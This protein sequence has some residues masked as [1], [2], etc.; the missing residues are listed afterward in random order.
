[1]FVI[2]P[3]TRAQLEQLARW[4]YEPP[5]N[6][7]DEA[8]AMAETALQ[9]SYL[10]L[11]SDLVNI[12][13]A[14]AYIDSPF[15]G[16]FREDASGELG[17]L[18][19]FVQY[20]PMVSEN[21]APVIRLGLGMNPAQCGHGLGDAFVRAIL[22]DARDRYPSA[23]IDLEVHTW[24]IRAIKVYERLGFVI[25]DTYRLHEDLCDGDDCDVHNMVYN[26]A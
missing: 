16:V 25:V 18:F 12:D 7:Y 22:T 17:E 5:Y 4:E 21:N 11:E 14:E 8:F 2:K 19:G 23:T 3:L 6:I 24:N 13:L 15:L 9:E 1:M 26:P 10:G 20:F